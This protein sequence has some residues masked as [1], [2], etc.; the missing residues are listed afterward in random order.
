M[1]AGLATEHG[2]QKAVM[3]DA[4]CLN[5][6]RTRTSLAAKKGARGRRIGRTKGDMNAKL[7]AICDR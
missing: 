1:T 7:H 4:T 2:E 3:I 6:H 5:T